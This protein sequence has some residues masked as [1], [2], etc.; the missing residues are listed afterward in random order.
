MDGQRVT[1]LSLCHQTVIFY[2]LNV[3]DL[4]KSSQILAK[5]YFKLGSVTSSR[6]GQF[7]ISHVA[8]FVSTSCCR[9][10]FNSMENV[11]VRCSLEISSKLGN[12]L[13]E[14]VLKC[15]STERRKNPAP[16]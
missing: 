5:V 8:R 4:C 3:K 16:K 9:K 6:L 1:L 10:S 14:E 11:V 15:V 13:Q 12:A 7:N 2:N